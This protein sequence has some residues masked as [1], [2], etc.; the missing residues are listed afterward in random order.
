MNNHFDD[1]KKQDDAAGNKT[2]K[3]IRLDNLSDYIGSG[4]TPIAAAAQSVKDGSTTAYGAATPSN[5]GTIRHSSPKKA[6]IAAVFDSGSG[7][8]QDGVF[9]SATNDEAYK[10]TE[11]ILNSGSGFDTAVQS[12][13]SSGFDTAVN[14]ASYDGSVKDTQ[15]VY[16]FDAATRAS[17]FTDEAVSDYDTPKGIDTAAQSVKEKP[18][19]VFIIGAS[20]GIGEKTAE[21]FFD[22]GYTVYN[23]SR[24]VCKTA[25]IKNITV[26]VVNDDTIYDAI[27]Q[28]ITAEAKI[29]IFIYSAGFSLSAPVENTLEKD[30]RYLFD[31]NFFGFAK[32]VKAV[33]ASMRDT[34]GGKIIAVSSMGG[35]FPI[36]FDAF[37]SASKAALN[38]FVRSLAIELEPY[39]I[40]VIS[41]M[42]GGTATGFTRKRKVYP[43]DMTGI[44]EKQL[45]KANSALAEMEQNGMPPEKVA[46]AIADA[47]QN[48]TQSGTHAVGLKNKV[49][50]AADKVLPENITLAAI[51]SR[52]RQNGNM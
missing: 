24:T 48:D 12:E 14:S 8:T 41:V 25:G 18:K 35:I 23:G 50:A 26:D 10:N 19:V 43:P 30:Y 40:K 4:G 42:P 38:M 51:K 34:G 37:Y 21:L 13:S 20:D 27:A 49:L 7:F 33:T 45:M 36:A 17:S 3:I 11:S 52:Y 47:A 1:E 15:A 9:A 46:Q 32:T 28:I 5:D 2:E 22:K 29:D 6:E 44:Y 16:G 31:V 39:N